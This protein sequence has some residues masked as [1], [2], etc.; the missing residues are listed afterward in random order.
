V[1]GD[2][3]DEYYGAEEK[4][5]EQLHLRQRRAIN[6]A[7]A[8]LEGRNYANSFAAFTFEEAVDA[9]LEL[10]GPDTGTQVHPCRID[11][12]EAIRGELNQAVDELKTVPPE[13]FLDVNMTQS[14]NTPDADD[15]YWQEDS[16]VA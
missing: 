15:E 11:R 8:A 4:Q 7:Y 2:P 1:P 10:I 3:K 6:N 9:H 16:S 14:A 13:T 5:Q 12:V